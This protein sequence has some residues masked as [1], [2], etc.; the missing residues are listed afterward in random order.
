MDSYIVT[1][2][3]KGGN[4][5]FFVADTTKVIEEARKI[6]MCTPT[7]AAALGR[8]MT[9][10]AMMGNLGKNED[11]KLTLQFRGDGLIKNIICVADNDVNVK[12]YVSN[13]MANPPLRPDGKLDVGGA[14]GKGKLI[15]VRDL[16]LREPYVGQSELVNGEIA[17]DIASYFALSE[18]QPSAVALGVLID[19][20]YSVKAAGGFIIQVMPDAKEEAIDKLEEVLRNSKPMSALIA[21]G[22]T[23][24]RILDEV[25]V[26]FEVEII[27]KKEVKSVCDCSREKI[28]EV[29][30]SLG[31]KEIREM[32]ENDKGTEVLCHFCNTKYSFDEEDLKK[33]IN[34]KKTID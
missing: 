31:E 9:A 12:G 28:E 19:V 15:V 32:I 13:P 29:I 2:I 34:S 21:E 5:R 23:P 20:D 25:F 33:L 1:G 4:F 26:D 27:G 10:A 22:Y 8:A 17:E 18:Q 11:E 6:H 24:E 16:G 14:I 3:D 7:A 30:I